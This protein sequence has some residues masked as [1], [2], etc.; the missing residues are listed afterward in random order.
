MRGVAARINDAAI[1]ESERRIFG[2][3]PAGERGIEFPLQ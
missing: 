1:S 3:R 2:P